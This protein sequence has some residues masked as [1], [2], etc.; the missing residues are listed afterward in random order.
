M[1]YPENECGTWYKEVMAE[2]NIRQAEDST[3]HGDLNNWEQRCGTVFLA[4]LRSRNYLFSAQTPI[5]RL[6]PQPNIVT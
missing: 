2:D 6:R 4:V 1:Q 3:Q 5:F